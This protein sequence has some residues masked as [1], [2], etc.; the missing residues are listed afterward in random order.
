MNKALTQVELNASGCGMPDCGHDHSV[1]ILHSRC[2]TRA[3]TWAEYEKASGILTIKCA[4]CQKI[5]AQLKI[6]EV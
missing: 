3:G 4:R 6:A 2:H 5:V 1:L